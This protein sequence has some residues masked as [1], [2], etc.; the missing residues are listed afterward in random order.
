ML[1]KKIKTEAKNY[2]HISLL[3]LISKL[4]EKSIYSQTQDY[5]Q[6]NEYFYN[7]HSRF[8]ANHSTDTC[9]SWLTDMILN[10]AENRK[11]TSMIL[12]HLQKAFDFLDHKVLLGKMKCIGFSSKTV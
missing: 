4:I 7:Y 1:K 3:P 8:R 10:G 12:I 5:L 9:L 6:R 2:R 11:H